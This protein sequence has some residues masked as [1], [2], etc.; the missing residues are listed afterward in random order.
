QDPDFRV[1]L[2]SPMTV[3]EHCGY[4]IEL[5]SSC[6]NSA[7]GR[8]YLN[9]AR[10]VRGARPF[11]GDI[12][13]YRQYLVNHEV[14]HAVG[15][16]DH[17]PCP[18]DG[19]LAPIMMQQTF[20]VDNGDIFSLDPEGVVPDNDDT[21]R[22][23]AWPYPDGPP[24]QQRPPRAATPT[25]V[26]PTAEASRRW[27]SRSPGCPPR[28]GPSTRATCCSTRWAT[29]GSGACAPRRYSSWARAAWARRS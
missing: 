2:T 11:Q 5:E 19:A 10:W 29:R 6:Y 28:S 15:Y 20:G 8:V 12:G 9:L 23:N 21:C 1:S 26:P 18:E 3:R 25:T 13:S 27:W 24:E 17:E 7:T 16:P 4:D 22:Y 14:G